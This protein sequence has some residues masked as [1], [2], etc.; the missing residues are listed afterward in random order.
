M[1][2]AKQTPEKLV[3]G[4]RTRVE[5]Q[6]GEP[7]HVS[8]EVTPV[9]RH[10]ATPW[11]SG[12]VDIRA[13]QQFTCLVICQTQSMNWRKT[14]ERSASAWF[15][16][17]WPTLWN[18]AGQRTWVIQGSQGNC[19]GL[20]SATQAFNKSY[21]KV[22]INPDFALSISLG[23]GAK[24]SYSFCLWSEISLWGYFHAKLKQEL[25]E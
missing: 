2:F 25:F 9:A 21:K 22:E 6:E 17:P 8:L 4:V 7:V 14:G 15:L 1:Y 5:A 11:Y 16:S 24:D 3:A 23:K 18:R 13:T 12:F 19:W 10:C 20:L